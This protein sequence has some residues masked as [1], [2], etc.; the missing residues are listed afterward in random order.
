[1]S[2]D[3]LARLDPRAAARIQ[4]DADGCWLYRCYLNRGYAN[5]KRGRRGSVV[6]WQAHRYTYTLLVGEIPS[7]L[8]LDHLCRVRNCVN[9]DHLEPVTRRENLLR[10]TSFVAR[11]AKQTHCVNGHL[12][13][14]ANTYVRPDRGT[15]EC[16]ACRADSLDRLYERRRLAS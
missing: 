9:P 15:R 14:E 4:V 16:R 13:D 8:E 12:F 10:S 5:L 6:R 11:K 7:G 1:M 3:R 2:L